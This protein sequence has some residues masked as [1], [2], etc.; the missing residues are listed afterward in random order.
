M[1]TLTIKQGEGTG[2]CAVC[3][4][5]M[6]TNT[7]VEQVYDFFNDGRQYGDPIH[8]PELAMYL[9]KHGWIMG[10]GWGFTTEEEW[11]DVSVGSP[12]KLH[13]LIEGFVGT[14]AYLAVKSRNYEGVTHA[15]YWDGHCVRDPDPNMPDESPISDYKL[16][17]IYPLHFCGFLD[18]VGRLELRPAELPHFVKR[19]REKGVASVNR[20]RSQ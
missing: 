4:A 20:G 11:E 17:E 5:A 8:D 10:C 9:L 13:M 1:T 18:L 6:V 19:W 16:V 15:V 3:V 7:T 14:P 2:M 12:D